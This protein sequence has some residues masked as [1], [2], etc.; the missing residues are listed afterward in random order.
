VAGLARPFAFLRRGAKKD[1]EARRKSGHD[2][3]K[4]APMLRKIVTTFVVVPLGLVLVV[5]AVANRH[6]VTVSLDPFGSDAPALSATVPLFIVILLCLLIGVIV[7][8]VATW[9][10]QGRW[11]RAAR[12][13]D[14][15]A[16]ALRIEREALKGELAAKEP[17]PLSLPSR[18]S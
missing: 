4:E 8:G 3:A 7:G 16:R 12:R 1:M 5:F 17:T 11:R 14:S 18:A 9:I 15:D 6:A 2:E 10:S 13:L